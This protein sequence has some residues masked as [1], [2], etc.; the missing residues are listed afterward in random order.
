M[1]VITVI[2]DGQGQVCIA[3]T[4]RAALQYLVRKKWVDQNSNIWW[5]DMEEPWR[6][7]DIT[8]QTLFG[9]DWLEGFMGLNDEQL[10]HMYL[11]FNE[12]ELIE[13]EN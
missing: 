3:S 6:G 2:V 9:D 12:M 10:E 5:P 1:K 13:E 7:Y 4:R 8:L 11:Y